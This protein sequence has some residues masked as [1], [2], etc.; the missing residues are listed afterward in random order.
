M[1]AYDDTDILALQWLGLVAFLVLLCL[2]VGWALR[3]PKRNRRVALPPPSVRC[4][5]GLD[6]R[7]YAQPPRRVA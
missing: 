1:S 7:A 5:R 3:R 4:Q 2:V 6:W